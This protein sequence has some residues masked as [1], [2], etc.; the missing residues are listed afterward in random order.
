MAIGENL[1]VC[2]AKLCSSLVQIAFFHVTVQ[3]FCVSVWIFPVI[4]FLV[5]RHVA[6]RQCF[7]PETSDLFKQ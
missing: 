1:E 5:K 2:L 4:E 6:P 7:A 3:F